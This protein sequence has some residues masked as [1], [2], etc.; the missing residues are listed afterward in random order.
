VRATRLSNASY[1]LVFVYWSAVLLC[2]C[3]VAMG[4]V[5]MRCA[6]WATNEPQPMYG[7]DDLMMLLMWRLP[8]VAVYLWL[9]CGR[10]GSFRS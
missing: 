3:V 5:A 7:I 4:G 10:R 9:M 2:A 1:V 6:G 8:F